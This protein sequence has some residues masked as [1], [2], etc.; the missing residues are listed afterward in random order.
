MQTYF[1]VCPENRLRWGEL[2]VDSF[3]QYMDAVV[4]QRQLEDGSYD[5]LS[6]SD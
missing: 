5:S 6:W 3:S 1:R 4:I 2:A